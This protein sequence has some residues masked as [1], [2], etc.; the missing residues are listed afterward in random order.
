MKTQDLQTSNKYIWKGEG[1]IE[2]VKFIGID[3][4]LYLFQRKDGR[5]MEL[6]ID[7]IQSE[8]NCR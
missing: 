5:T 8:I 1:K 7:E 6:F 2:L 4:N 3:R